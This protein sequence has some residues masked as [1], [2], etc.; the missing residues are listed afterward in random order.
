MEKHGSQKIPV[1]QHQIVGGVFFSL[2]L[3]LMKKDREGKRHEWIEGFVK[4]KGIRSLVRSVV[5]ELI[6]EIRVFEDKRIEV[7]FRYEDRYREAV[8]LVEGAECIPGVGGRE[9]S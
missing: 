3:L 7:R 1:L 5:V 2:G 6:E 4:N 9:V 8:E